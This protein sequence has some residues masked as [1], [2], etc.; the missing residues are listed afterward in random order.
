MELTKD[1]KKKQLIEKLSKIKNI[2][3][4]QAI[5]LISALETYC[6][7]IIN[8]TLKKSNEQH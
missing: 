6:E 8:Y 4:D 7:L 5:Q 3:T 1:E 2:S